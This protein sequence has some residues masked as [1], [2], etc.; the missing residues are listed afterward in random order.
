MPPSLSKKTW[1][2]ESNTRFEIR[3]HIK[4]TG[5]FV[6]GKLPVE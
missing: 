2:R 5:I 1:Y 4:S 6:K 3:Q